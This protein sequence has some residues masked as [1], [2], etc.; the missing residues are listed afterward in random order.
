MTVRNTFG[1]GERIPFRTSIMDARLSPNLIAEHAPKNW[2]AKGTWMKDQYS[3]AWIH[4]E[5]KRR[6]TD[7]EMCQARNT[8]E[9]A[10]LMVKAVTSPVPLT[11]AG[12]GYSG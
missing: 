8:Q 10:M 9:V 6:I 11:N 4:V 12:E 1:S 7:L 2:P 3:K 5:T